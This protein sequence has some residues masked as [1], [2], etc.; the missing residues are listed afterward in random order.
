MSGAPTLHA[1]LFRYRLPLSRALAMP[2]GAYAEREGVL[3]R[4]RDGEGREGWGEAAPLPGYSPDTLGEAVGALRAWVRDRTA[5]GSPS[6]RWAVAQA[7]AELHA[8]R[9]GVSLADAYGEPGAAPGSAVPTVFLNALLVGDADPVAAA[10]E[11]RAA[12]YRAAKLKVGRGS[13]G[14]DAELARAV[15]AALGPAT[16]RLDANGAWTLDEAT[17]F[18]EALGDVLVEYVEEP[19]ADPAELPE[20]AR[21][22]PHV[23]WA[24]DENLGEAFADP[25]LAAAMRAAVVKPMLGPEYIGQA[26]RELAGGI[27]TPRPET[28]RGPVVVSSV[29]ES[30]VGIRHLVALAA[31]LGGAPVGL[32]TYRW[33]AEDV[34]TASLALGGPAVD[35]AAVLSPNPVGLGR[36]TPVPL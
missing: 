12:G 8:V 18:A 22:A 33:L 32:D 20:L 6:A 24:L 19:L 14:G 27:W 34:L 9:C 23:R 11:A 36:L 13:P 25:A 3:L 21:R 30:G 17:A 31:A 4:L 26:R 1:E 35:V 16:L 7:R 29:F 10:A 15:Q 2:S 5:A 28:H